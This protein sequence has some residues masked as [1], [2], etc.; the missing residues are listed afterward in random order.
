MPGNEL[1]N[2]ALSRKLSATMIF[3]LRFFYFD[4]ATSI[5]LAQRVIPKDDKYFRNGGSDLFIVI[6]AP[7]RAQAAPTTEAWGGQRTTAAE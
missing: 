4:F 2:A 5:F 3:L 1:G 6:L 7:G